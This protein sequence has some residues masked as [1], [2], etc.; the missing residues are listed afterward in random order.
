MHITL[1]VSVRDDICT[2]YGQVYLLPGLYTA[3]MGTYVHSQ[4]QA[5]NVQYN[6]NHISCTRAVTQLAFE[7]KVVNDDGLAQKEI[8]SSAV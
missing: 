2:P 1:A 4:R 8:E 3:E 5:D 6:S 7:R